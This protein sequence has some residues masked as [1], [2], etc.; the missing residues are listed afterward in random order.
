MQKFLLI[1]GVILL[2]ACN[3]VKPITVQETAI[4]KPPLNLMVKPLVLKDVNFQMQDDYYILDELNFQNMS[5]NQLKILWKLREYQIILN[6][7]QNY[8]EK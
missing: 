1:L 5:E 8:Y 7:Y 4:V 2:T 3:T 6:S